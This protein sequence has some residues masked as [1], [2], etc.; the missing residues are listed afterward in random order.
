ME[1]MAFY[2]L[3]QTNSSTYVWKSWLQRDDVFAASLKM[4]YFLS[5]GYHPLGERRKVVAYMKCWIAPDLDS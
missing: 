3:I 5:G 2:R 4:F 1:L